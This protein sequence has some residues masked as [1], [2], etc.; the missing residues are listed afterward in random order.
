MCVETRNTH[1]DIN[2]SGGKN[3]HGLGKVIAIIIFV[4]KNHYTIRLN[5]N[6]IGRIKARIDFKYVI[7]LTLRGLYMTGF[8]NLL[9][10]NYT[11]NSW[12][13]HQLQSC[14]YYMSIDFLWYGKHVTFCLCRTKTFAMQDVHGFFFNSFSLPC[15]SNT[16]VLV[17]WFF[18]LSQTFSN[19]F[20]L[21]QEGN[22]RHFMFCFLK[23]RHTALWHFLMMYRLVIIMLPKK[24][25]QK[26]QIKITCVYF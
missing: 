17:D 26:K 22:I 7:S 21:L 10:L 2:S 3:Q 11:I 18:S 5:G 13:T 23:T 24:K 8:L 6:F 1:N 9:K 4:V 25:Q 14:N 12:Y 20:S 15:R 16:Y 19:A